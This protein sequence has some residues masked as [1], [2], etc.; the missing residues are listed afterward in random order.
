MEQQAIS[1]PTRPEP[2][3]KR[4]RAKGLTWVH[5]QSRLGRRIA[6]LKDIYTAA[7]GGSDLL[8]PIKHLRIA[9]AA[10][11][12][13]LA[14]KA[15]GEFMRDGTGHLNQVVRAERRAVQAERA[16]GVMEQSAGAKSI[17]VALA[18]GAR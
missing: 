9:E 5:P 15:R 16:L 1:A 6:E 2:T 17:L 3:P 12:K 14:E 4:S 11:L 7:V 10:E 8:S 18:E 13:A